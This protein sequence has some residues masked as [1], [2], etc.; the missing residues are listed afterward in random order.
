MTFLNKIFIS[1]LIVLLSGC[2]GKTVYVDRPVEVKVPVKCQIQKPDRPDL[3]KDQSLSA[4]L[5]DL[6]GY[7]LKLEA[8][9]DTCQ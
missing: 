5:V 1:A 7:I 8:A 9:I 4:I 6:K 3:T 2:A